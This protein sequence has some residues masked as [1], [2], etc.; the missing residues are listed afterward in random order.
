LIRILAIGKN[1]DKA[2]KMQEAEYLK[3]LQAFGKFEVIEFKDEANEKT[4]TPA[5][6]RMVKDNEADR[7]LKKISP[8]DFVIL[9]D[10]H[11][12]MVD[13]IQFSKLFSDWQMRHSNLVFVIAG[14]LGPA[15]KLV[16][17]ANWR[18]KLSDLTFTHL[19]SRILLLEQLYRAC[20]INANRTYHK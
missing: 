18:W 16:A 11:G 5:I 7:V 2:L 6:A 14:S 17:R 1:K 15:P 20:M 19:M 3:R 8:D 12:D 4:D 9:L 10:L 13:S